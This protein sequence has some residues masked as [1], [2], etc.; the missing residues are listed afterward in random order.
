M[1]NTDRPEFDKH[2][3]V[4]FAAFDRNAT[5]ER[6][7]AYWLGLLDVRLSEIVANVAKLCKLARKGQPVPKP[8]ELR[9]VL[10]QSEYQPKDPKQDAAFAAA[11]AFSARTWDELLRS[12]PEMGRIELTIASAGRILARDFEGSPHYAEAVTADRNARN[13]R[14]TLWRNRAG[15]PA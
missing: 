6:R 13:A 5:D 12:D 7:E 14:V 4:L 8:S 15:L 11:E 1:L 2:I 10:P 3:G 9:N